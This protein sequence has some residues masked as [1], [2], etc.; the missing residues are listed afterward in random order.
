MRRLK[1]NIF[2][3]GLCAS[4]ILTAGCETTDGPLSAA[5]TASLNCNS[6]AKGYSTSCALILHAPVGTT[7]TAT[8]TEGDDWCRLTNDRVSEVSETMAAT[9]SMQWV[10]FSQNVDDIRHASI[11][12]EFDNGYIYELPFRQ[13]VFDAPES[14]DKPWNELPRYRLDDN[15]EYRSHSSLM[16]NAAK[17][18]YTYCFD[19]VHHV[20]LWVAY[21]LHVCYTAGSANRNYSDFGYDPDVTATWQAN[22]VGH[23][24]S[25]RYDR[26]HQIPAADRKCEQSF[27]NQTFYATNMT[28]QQSDFNQH[29]WGNLEGK[30]RGQICADTLYVVTGCYF[31]SDVEYDSSIARET[32]DFT[33]R[34]MPIPSQS[35]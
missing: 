21:P 30:V 13:T 18:N 27:M 24:Y 16:Q 17:R 7:Y 3:L 2:V 10:R 31:G 8:V 29:L 34:S 25:G 6:V 9:E 28:P 33:G 20:S 1:F 4:A 22:L 23:S 11:R 5:T 35:S 15:F 26:G 14:Y 19:K 32:T 12:V